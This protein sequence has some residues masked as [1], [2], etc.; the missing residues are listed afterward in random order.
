MQAHEEDKVTERNTG[1]TF[2]RRCASALTHP[3]TLASISVLLVN[4]IVLKSLWP[5]AWVTGKLSDLAWVVFASPLLAFL[6]SFVTGS[7][8]SSQRAVFLV[9]YVGLPALYAAFNTFEPVHEWILSGISLVSGGTAGSPLDVTDSLVIPFGLGIALWVWRRGALS[10]SSLRLR[11]GLLVAAIAALASVAT[12]EIEPDLG[13]VNVSSSEYGIVRAISSF[14]GGVGSHFVSRDGGMTWSQEDNLPDAYGWDSLGPRL[15]SVATKRGQYLIEGTEILLVDERGQSET[16]YSSTYLLSFGNKWTQLQQTWLSEWDEVPTVPL[17]I[18][19]DEAS[20]NLIA[21]MGIQGVVVGDSSGKWTRIEVE[22][23]S[24]TDFAFA[25]KTRLMASK[26]AFWSTVL[27]FSLCMTSCAI[28][29]SRF[30]GHC[31]TRTLAITSALFSGAQVLL[32]PIL[33]QN[34]IL[35]DGIGFYLLSSVAFL[36][37]GTALLLSL[38]SPRV[39]PAIAA[40]FVLMIAL[41]VFSFMLWLHVDN[42]PGLA[43]L[44]PFILTGLVAAGLVRYL[45]LNQPPPDSS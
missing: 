15:D 26:G 39:I 31:A 6:L 30:W 37:G 18:A 25:G 16:A 4:D 20:G 10:D 23:Y 43:F 3:V 44:S 27:A 14:G 32:F 5:N 9:A 1:G 42:L 41:T 13:I 34:L 11:A 45:D 38:P 19:Y 7:N 33:D 17:A 21:A 36:L 29:F 35:G 24:P 40:A 22:R 2:R 12:S 8:R 28:T